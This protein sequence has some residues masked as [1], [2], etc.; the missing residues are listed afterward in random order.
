MLAWRSCAGGYQFDFTFRDRQNQTAIITVVR[1]ISVGDLQMLLEQVRDF[2]TKLVITTYS[3]KL[4][5]SC[6]IFKEALT[7]LIE[8]GRSAARLLFGDKFPLEDSGETLAFRE[9]LS[10]TLGFAAP[11][12]KL[13]VCHKVSDLWVTFC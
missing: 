4:T 1:N 13:W 2:W 5:P 10:Q 12:A 3:T 9:R 7:N 8:I 6:V 11:T